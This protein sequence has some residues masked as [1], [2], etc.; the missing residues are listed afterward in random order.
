MI[1]ELWLPCPDFE[2]FYEVSNLGKIRRKTGACGTSKGRILKPWTDKAGRQ[3]VTLSV[4]CKT[5]KH[6]VSILVCRAW[7]GPKPTPNHQV[8]HW[9]GFVTNNS[10]G[11]LRWATQKENEQDK[12]RHGKYNHAPKGSKNSSAKLSEGDISKI[13]NLRKAGVSYPKLAIKFGVSHPAIRA[14]ILGRTW[15]HV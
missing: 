12:I 4:K 2:I 11:N 10:S 1:T 14:I 5:K 13:R 3:I 6:L 8:A 9:D 7:H 15:K